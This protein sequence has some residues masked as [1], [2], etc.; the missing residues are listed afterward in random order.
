MT[1]SL[2]YLPQLPNTWSYCRPDQLTH[3]LAP[4]KQNVVCDGRS[5][6]DVI[7]SSEDYRLVGAPKREFNASR[8]PLVELVMEPEERIVLIMEST[9]SMNEND[10]WKWIQKVAHKII[11]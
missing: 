3:Q 8:S 5:A 11:R 1:C 9:A 7:T 6:Y 2:G 4:T 10:D